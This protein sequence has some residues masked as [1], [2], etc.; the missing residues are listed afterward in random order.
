M[1]RGLDIPTSLTVVLFLSARHSDLFCGGGGAI[2]VR[3]CVT[4]MW[5][6]VKWPAHDTSVWQRFKNEH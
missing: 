1:T 3:H 4:I 5:I 2:G 6:H